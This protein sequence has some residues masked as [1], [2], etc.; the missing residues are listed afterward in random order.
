MQSKELIQLFFLNGRIYHYL[1]WFQECTFSST[2]NTFYKNGKRF[3]PVFDF[4][5]V[6]SLNI[7][8]NFINIVGSD[9]F[10]FYLIWII[11][12]GPF[13][14]FMRPKMIFLLFILKQLTFQHTFIKICFFRKYLKVYQII[15]G[16]KSLIISYNLSPFTRFPSSTV[17]TISVRRSGGL[18]LISDIDQYEFFFQIGNLSINSTKT[19][20][21]LKSFYPNR[22][23]NY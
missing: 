10:N 9:V 20:C 16:T 2:N 3:F 5:P 8:D 12:I 18:I 7:F 11:S 13:N 15:F 4:L 1:E 6:R 17:L 23:P 19:N 21:N 22:F 14:N